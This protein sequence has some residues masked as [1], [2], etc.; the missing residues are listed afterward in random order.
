MQSKFKKKFPMELKELFDFCISKKRIICFVGGGGKTS[1]IYWLAEQSAKAGKK[2][3]VSTTTHILRPQYCFADTEA[4]VLD[5]WSKGHY[6]VIG[7][8]DSA[9]K[10]KLVFP[11]QDFYENIKEKADLILLEADGAKRLPCKIPA[12][13]EPVIVPECDLIIG[14][15]GMSA[16]EKRISESCFRFDTNGTWLDLA[17]DTVID[18]VIAAKILSSE[19]GTRKNVGD[20]EYIVVLNQCDNENL[21]KRAQTIA[22]KLYSTCGIES[23]CCHLKEM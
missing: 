6:A 4:A 5:L 22:D 10:E 8:L 15:M 20:R 16:L 18:E 1:L 13:H 7:T 2:T 17:K 23:V 19:K 3:I 14:L 21:L 9:N 12:E 11:R